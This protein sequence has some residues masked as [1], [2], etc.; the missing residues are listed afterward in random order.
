[1]MLDARHELCFLEFV[2]DMNAISKS[3]SVKKTKKKEEWKPTGK[4]FTKIGYQWRPT[5]RTFNL[6]GNTT[7]PDTSRGSNTSVT[8]S[9]SSSSSVD[10]RFIGTVKFGNDQIAKIMGYGDY[11]IGNITFS[12]VYYVEGLGHNLF[13]VGQ[14]YDSDLV[15]AF[16][17][18]TC[19]VRNLEVP[20]AAAPR[21]VDLAD[22][23]VCTSIDQNAPSASIPSTQ[24]QEHSLIISQRFE[25]SPKTPYFHDDPLHESLHEDSIS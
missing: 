18:H 3:K 21:A 8:P 13:S 7:E 10:L 16:R 5:K 6:V 25:E 4:V 12:R 14:F 20:I 15:V 23:P 2:S 9:S 22:S 17:K 24:D 19:C 1:S 11:Q